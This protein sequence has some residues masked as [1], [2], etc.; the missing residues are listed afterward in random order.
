MP[1]TL[2]NKQINQILKYNFRDKEKQ[3]NII[4]NDFLDTSPLSIETKNIDF[5]KITISKINDNDT[6]IK[7]YNNKFYR[8]LIDKNTVIYQGY[9][10]KIK[11][12]KNPCFISRMFLKNSEEKWSI[13]EKIVYINKEETNIDKKLVV[14][15]NKYDTTEEIEKFCAKE[16]IIENNNK[17]FTI[18]RPIQNWILEKVEQKSVETQTEINLLSKKESNWKRLL[19][20]PWK[21]IMNNKAF[22]FSWNGI[23]ILGSV[24]T[25]IVGLLFFPAVLPTI[26][27]VAIIQLL[28]TLIA[29]NIVAAVIKISMNRDEKKSKEQLQKKEQQER[30]SKVNEHINDKC[31]DFLKNYLKLEKN[32]PVTDIKTEFK[33]IYDK[34]FDKNVKHDNLN[35]EMK[36]QSIDTQSIN[37]YDNE[38]IKNIAWQKYVAKI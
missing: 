26:A 25:T 3:Q 15:F 34:N 9:L 18:I 13:Y 4:S 7:Y 10:E 1:K 31:H 21:W 20:K 36:D 14:I 19:F 37:N 8:K 30:N 16:Q 29:A 22:L 17:S 28:S 33:N 23:P 32:K 6:K 12:N 35:I 11:D 27:L 38:N 24:I 5:T 2:N